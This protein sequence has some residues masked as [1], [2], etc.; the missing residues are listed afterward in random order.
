MRRGG[1]ITK[2]LL[3]VGGNTGAKCGIFAYRVCMRLLTFQKT[4]AAKKGDC[5]NVSQMFALLNGYV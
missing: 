5:A 3:K 4:V 1:V 2:F